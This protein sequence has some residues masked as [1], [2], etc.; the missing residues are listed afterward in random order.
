V[1]VGDVEPARGRQAGQGEEDRYHHDVV[2]HGRERGG[3]E[4]P[5]G[6]EHRGGE[7]RNPVEEDLRHEQA[8]EGRRERDLLRAVLALEVQ[9]EEA[10]DPR[11]GHHAEHRD[12]DQPGEGQGVDGRARRSCRSA[13]LHVE[14]HERGRED[15]ARAARRPCWAS[16]S[17]CCRRR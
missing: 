7:G 5:A 3:G 6:V 16:S 13:V 11:R 14:R 17:R 4:A 12:Q 10:D 8:K 2:E 1:D 15:A 9:R